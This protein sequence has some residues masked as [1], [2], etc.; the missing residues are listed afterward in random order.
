MTEPDKKIFGHR[1]SRRDLFIAAAA[2]AVGAG[3]K[4]TVSLLTNDKEASPAVPRY[5]YLPGHIADERRR[6]R[7]GGRQGLVASVR[8][9]PSNGNI[10]IKAGTSDG[11]PVNAIT[12]LPALTA[13][14]GYQDGMTPTALRIV[15]NGPASD[16]L[17]IEVENRD[18]A[19]YRQLL[20]Q[21]ET[22][23]HVYGAGMSV[24][25]YA[26]GEDLSGWRLMPFN[27]TQIQAARKAVDNLVSMAVTEI[28]GDPLS[29]PLQD[30]ELFGTRLP[31]PPTLRGVRPRTVTYDRPTSG[32]LDS[33]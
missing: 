13:N 18:S 26:A 27:L 11:T 8:I 6:I 24:D 16:G 15:P 33:I 4:P 9:D 28:S 21:I 20:L 10:T 2:A 7:L 19:P 22:P 14:D 31:M 5:M 32:D 29:N 23:G 1:F 30:D 17:S 25:F 3:T 12:L